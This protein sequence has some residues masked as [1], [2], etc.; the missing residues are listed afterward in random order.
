M[1]KLIA[2]W[3]AT[4]QLEIMAVIFGLAYI[5]LATREIVWCWLAGFIGCSISVALFASGKLYMEAGLNVFYA[6]MAIYGWWQWRHGEGEDNTLEIRRFGL[7]QHIATLFV[8]VCFASGFGF[9]LNH[10]TDAALPYLDSFT[11]GAA[12]ITTWMVARKILENWLYWIV[13][14]T[15]SIYLYLERGYYLYAALFVLY[16]IIAIFGF[17]QWLRSYRQPKKQPLELRRQAI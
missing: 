15:A 7:Q 14:N 9:F 17:W 2:A 12:M 11:T 13:I 8:V 3:Q 16:I 5:I 1:E 4:S 10:H 6:L